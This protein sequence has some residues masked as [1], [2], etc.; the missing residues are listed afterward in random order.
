MLQRSRKK[1]VV[2]RG[3]REPAG[4]K[5]KPPPVDACLECCKANSKK[6]DL[7]LKSMHRI[8]GQLDDLDA[9]VRDGF[10][11]IE[12]KLQN[13]DAKLDILIKRTEP[14]PEPGPATNVTIS[15]GEPAKK[16]EG[17]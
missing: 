5:P 11:S 16:P 7:L 13:M 3:E 10:R 1:V 17:G 15:L 12:V 8:E 6:I 14:A 2:G 4:R 9:A